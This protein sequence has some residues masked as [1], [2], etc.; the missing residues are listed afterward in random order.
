MSQ[1]PPELTTEYIV[2]KFQVPP[3]P[4][5]NSSAYYKIVIKWSNQ[6]LKNVE[7]NMYLNS[8]NSLFY[9]LIWI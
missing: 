9:P 5:S 1:Y 7:E 3:H 6:N 2:E 4:P 8:S